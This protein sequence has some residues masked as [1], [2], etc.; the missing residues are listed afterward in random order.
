MLFV[1]CQNHGALQQNWKLLKASARKWKSDG[2]CS[3][4]SAFI[5]FIVEAQLASLFS[6]CLELSKSK[7]ISKQAVRGWDETK[8]A[9]TWPRRDK[10]WSLCWDEV[11]FDARLRSFPFYRT[12]ALRRHECHRCAKLEED[13]RNLE[14]RDAK[15]KGRHLRRP[16]N[17]E[18]W[19][20]SFFACLRPRRSP[21]HKLCKAFNPNAERIGRGTLALSEMVKL[22]HLDQGF[23]S[24]SCFHFG[25]EGGKGSPCAYVLASET[26]NLASVLCLNGRSTKPR[27]L[28]KVCYGLCRNL[29]RI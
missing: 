10:F 4:C 28:E 21:T 5:L 13:A 8:I 19:T 14:Q 20:R 24:F 29:Q 26:R 12:G 23:W 1:D 17:F 11:A 6:Q 22:F 25:V 18:L 9:D 3:H 2:W 15:V 27:W 7:R 16:L